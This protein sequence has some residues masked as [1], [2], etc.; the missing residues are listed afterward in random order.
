MSHEQIQGYV[1]S[2]DHEGAD[3]VM[4]VLRGA[5]P[6]AQIFPGDVDGFTPFLET[7]FLDRLW[8]RQL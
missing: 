1:V 6:G 7:D 2:S 8:R 3:E 4:Q 5:L